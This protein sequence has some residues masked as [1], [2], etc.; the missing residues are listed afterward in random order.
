MNVVTDFFKHSERIVTT[1][2]WKH[3]TLQDNSYDC[4]VYM[5]QYVEEFIYHNNVSNFYFDKS[6]IAHKR[7]QL[8]LLISIHL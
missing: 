3:H 2:F 4:G 1:V 5:L 6:I 7:K 8:A